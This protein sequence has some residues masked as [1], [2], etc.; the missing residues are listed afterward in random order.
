MNRCEVCGQAA[1]VKEVYP[2]GDGPKTRWLCD[3]HSSVVGM[4]YGPP[5]LG[6]VDAEIREL[7][8]ALNR[9]EG[10]RT[11]CCC[12]G[13]HRD[14]VVPYVEM[15]PS[16]EDPVSRASFERFA[17]TLVAHPDLRRLF[18]IEGPP[19][20]GLHLQVMDCSNAPAAW[21]AL[22]DFIR[23]RSAEPECGI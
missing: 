16:A 8:H 21:E 4:P 11:L 22:L 12:S 14:A 13:T 19:G 2:Q 10:I 1:S 5:E 6:A 9:I 7:V 17:R 15:R 3:E 18:L 23:A 20:G